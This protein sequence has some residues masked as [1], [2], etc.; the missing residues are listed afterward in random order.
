MELRRVAREVNEMVETVWFLVGVG[1]T[2][3]AVA[4]I[5]VRL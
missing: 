2:L 5:Y 1:V 3:F 4:M